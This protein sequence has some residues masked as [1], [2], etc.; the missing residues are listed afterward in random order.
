MTRLSAPA[1]AAAAGAASARQAQNAPAAMRA[2][3]IGPLSYACILH[4]LRIS[5]YSS[6]FRRS[7]KLPRSISADLS[8]GTF[9]M[10]ATLSRRR[11]LQLSAAQA[12]I[13]GLGIPAWAQNRDAITIAFPTDVPTW[14]PNARVLVGVQSLYKCVFDSPLTQAPNLAVQPSLVKSWAWR[15]KL[16]LELVLRDDSVFH[17]GDSVTA[18][19]VRYTFFERPRAPVAKGGRK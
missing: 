1:R 11:L 18:A 16:T 8:G 13:G 4:R 19:D 5:R 10:T 17:N 7:R 15:D 12:T 14:D 2:I 6:A 9:S 3:M